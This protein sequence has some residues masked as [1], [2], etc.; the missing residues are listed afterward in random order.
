MKITVFTSNQPRHLALVRKLSAISHQT[1]A[2]LEC[3]T[4]FPGLVSDF[5]KKSDVM[6]EYFENVMRAEKT[7]Y[8]DVQF[9]PSNVRTLSVKSGDLN[10]LTYEALKDA[11]SSDVYI[12]F[13]ARYIKDWLVDFL[14]QHRAINIHMGISPYYR[15]S[16]CNFWAL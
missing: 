16:S 13:G 14:V 9:L 5:F 7:L 10:K 8:G 4:V 2:V 6:R 3:N 15:G 1:F 12:V 11:L